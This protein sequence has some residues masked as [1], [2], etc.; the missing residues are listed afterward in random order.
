MAS[1]NERLEIRQAAVRLQ[2]LLAAHA[3]AVASLSSLA[4]LN[5]TSELS[6]A[7][8][9]FSAALDNMASLEADYVSLRAL[10]A[11]AISAAYP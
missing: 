8:N 7:G 1:K 6:G 9:L 11:A 5:E 10:L 3:G 4:A 2:Q